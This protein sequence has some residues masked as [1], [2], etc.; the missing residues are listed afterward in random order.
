MNG[1]ILRFNDFPDPKTNLPTKRRPAARYLHPKLATTHPNPQKE[2][3]PTKWVDEVKVK[4]D[5]WATPGPYLRKKMLI[6]LARRV[7]DRFLPDAFYAGTTFENTMDYPTLPKEQ[8]V[9]HE[10]S[11]QEKIE[12][13][14]VEDDEE[15][16][17]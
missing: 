12:N 9:V 11:L 14:T 7:S 6:S 17:E 15:D 4:G 13:V 16:E 3:K 1:K 5:I 10:M 8:E 2:G